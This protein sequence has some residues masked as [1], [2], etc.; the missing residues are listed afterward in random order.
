MCTYSVATAYFYTPTPFPLH[1]HNIF[2][3]SENL[4]QR[5]TKFTFT[6]IFNDCCNSPTECLR[7][8]LSAHWHTEILFVC[9][10]QCGRSCRTL[11]GVLAGRAPLSPGCVEDESQLCW[12]SD[13]SETVSESLTSLARTA[14]RSC[15]SAWWMKL[16]F[17]DNPEEI[18]TLLKSFYVFQLL[19]ISEILH[20]F[21]N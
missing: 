3:L 11:P 19:D 10:H 15:G 8:H 14:I 20:L 9:T 4:P 21:M 12:W 2:Q 13:L 5:S 6:I 16:S 7:F 17:V 18:C 1:Y